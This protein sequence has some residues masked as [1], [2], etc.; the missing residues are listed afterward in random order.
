MERVF[1][2][3][4][5]NEDYSHDELGGIKKMPDIVIQ[6]ISADEVSKV[7]KYAYENNIPVTPRDQ[8]QDLLEQRFH[9]KVE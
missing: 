9:L 7:M 8:E 2:R 4:E 1:F 5:I 3:E 6:T